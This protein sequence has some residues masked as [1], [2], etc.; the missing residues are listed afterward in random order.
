LAL[1][2]DDGLVLNAF[3]AEPGPDSADA[4]NLLARW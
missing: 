1:T 4:L 3:T 2:A